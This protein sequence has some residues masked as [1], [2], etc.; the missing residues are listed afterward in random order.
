[1]NFTSCLR[2]PTLEF[3]ELADVAIPRPGKSRQGASW[4]GRPLGDQKSN[5]HD[6]SLKMFAA[7]RSRLVNSASGS[8]NSSAG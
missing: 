2:A 8:A 6:G 3:P 5:S 1:M 7:D 4:A